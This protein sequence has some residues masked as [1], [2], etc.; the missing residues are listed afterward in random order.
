MKLH[1]ND[2]VPL[3]A[4]AERR[5]P[6]ALRKKVRKEIEHLYQ[7]DIIEDITSEATPWLS[8]HVIVPTVMVG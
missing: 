2:K 7:Q 6:F 8:Q 4:Q 5:I 3:V 1:I